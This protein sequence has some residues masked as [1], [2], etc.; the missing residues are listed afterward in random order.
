MFHK[1]SLEILG[2]RYCS[3]QWPG[4]SLYRSDLRWVLFI[5]NE[6][7][8]FQDIGISLEQGFY[9]NR[10][11]SGSLAAKEGSLAIGDR[12]LSVRVLLFVSFH[13]SCCHDKCL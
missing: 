1:L 8:I 10:L 6:V 11:M 5:N 7:V 9:V 13:G 12:I 2:A 4:I 3:A